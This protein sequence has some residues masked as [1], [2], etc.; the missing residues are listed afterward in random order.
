MP[1]K[2]AQMLTLDCRIQGAFTRGRLTVMSHI[3][4]KKLI[5]SKGMTT[6]EVQQKVFVVALIYELG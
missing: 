5:Q 1:E 2:K 4:R 6:S 3:L